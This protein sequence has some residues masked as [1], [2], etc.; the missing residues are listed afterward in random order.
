[1][2]AQVKFDRRSFIKVTSVAGGGVLFGF[3]FFA[4]SA[5][6]AA[7][8][9]PL[10]WFDMN[11]FLK[12]AANGT[13]TIMSPNP[14]IGQGV[15]TAM[16]MVVAEELDV[17]W[18]DVVVEQAPLD[19]EKYRRQVAGG[20]GS[21]RS[22]WDALRRAGATARQMLVNAAAQKWQVDATECTTA[23]GKVLHKASTKSASYG[24]LAAA[25]VAM[26]VPENVELKDPKDFKL[27]GTAIKNVD[28]QKIITGQPLFGMDTQREG[29][30][31]A[32]A[33]HPPAFGMKLKSVDHSKATAMPGI[34]KVV[35]FDNIVAVTGR[36]TWEVMKARE[37]L[38]I[39]WETDT[40]P[41]N[42]AGHNRLLDEALLKQPEEIA[43][44]DGDP[45]K[46][47]RTAAK[48]FE[49][50]YEAPFL[51]HNTMEPMNFF[52]GVRDGK[53][54]LL[55][56]IQTPEGTRRYV[57][58]KLGVNESSI[59]LMLTRMGGG[60]GRRLNGDF[61]VEAAMISKLVGAP[62]KLMYT[63]ED[64]MTKG[65]YRP[66]LKSTY[67]AALD[68]HGN[69]IGFHVRGAGINGDAVRP[70]NFPAGAIANYLA[71]NHQLESN[72]TTGAWRSPV[73]NFVGFA[74]QSFLEELAV[75]MG[76]DPV[77]FRLEL[78][79]NAKNNPAGELQYDPDRFAGVIKLA[80]EK[81]G[82]GTGKAGVH[83]G[84]AAYYSHNTYVAEV[85]EVVMQENHPK[86]K[87][88]WCAVDCGIVVN[89]SGAETEAAGGIIDGIGHALYGELTFKDGAPQQQNFNRYQLIRI[90]DAPEVETFF[91]KNEEPPTGLGEPTLSLAQGALANALSAATGKRLYKQPFD[92]ALKA[93]G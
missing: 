92:A 49:R 27:I 32:M 60:F 53:V 39:E 20:S 31:I 8:S 19:T 86:V 43:R 57:A 87:K 2:Q 22:S 64:D 62:V 38:K 58:E 7:A 69:L 21:L 12:I 6:N 68:A 50:T 29:M 90:G 5:P 79:E 66:M 1:M 10:E 47:F 83:Q 51:P 9:V 75:E 67:R 28:N 74:E 24:E 46:T 54:E 35:T 41:E 88:V 56:P 55:G 78:L 4:G 81:S 65:V 91:V 3:N 17:D 34:E 63:R 15:K 42:T 72:I 33:V 80:A 85:V 45:E 59:S 18:A 11:A 37:A 16:P 13:I 93:L 61:V 89:L 25:A 23:S 30:L 84:F 44:K 48:I 26:E 40:P 52:A 77:Q 76:K 70:D 71:E 82:W 73:H 14:E 36:T